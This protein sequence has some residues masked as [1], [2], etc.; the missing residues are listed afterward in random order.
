MLPQKTKSLDRLALGT[1]IGLALPPL[2]IYLFYLTRHSPLGFGAFVQN[3]ITVQISSALLSV[4][5]VPNLAAF[6]LFLQS[7]RY[8]S[9]RGILL[10]TILWAFVGF[11]TKFTLG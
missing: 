2:A 7:D 1:L 4:S 5:V 9:A 10:A 11:G 3:A 8:Y 6:F